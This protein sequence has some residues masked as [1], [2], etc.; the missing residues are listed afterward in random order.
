[1]TLKFVDKYWPTLSVWCF[2]NLFNGFNV[3]FD[4]VNINW[5]YACKI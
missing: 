2:G 5:I 1:M 4:N 3:I